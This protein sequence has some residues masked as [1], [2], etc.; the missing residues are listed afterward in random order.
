MKNYIV[1][2]AGGYHGEFFIGNIVSNTD[3]FHYYYF[4]C[5]SEELNAYRYETIHLEDSSCQDIHQDRLGF[6]L[7]AEEQTEDDIDYYSVWYGKPI[8]TRTHDHKRVGTL[9][10]IRLLTN[11]PVYHRRVIL[12]QCIKTLDKT[13]SNI[14][15]VPNKSYE[16]GFQKWP[17]T[18]KHT[19]NDRLEVDIK[20]WLHNENLE[21]L[22]D[23][24]EIE[25][26]QA[27]K[28]AVTQYYERDEILLNRYF[29]DWQNQT[30]EHL[31]KEMARIDKSFQFLG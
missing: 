11:D 20:E 19:T 28:D 18:L 2:Y 31:I 22:E 4:K 27:M 24:L 12:L 25:Y 30:D 21:K 3:K 17:N 26:T 29:P 1:V 5:R 13:Y 8:I 7:I 16:S 10:T 23:F 6:P 9:P 14:N 15:G